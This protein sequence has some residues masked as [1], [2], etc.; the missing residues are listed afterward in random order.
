MAGLTSIFMWVTMP[1][2]M[3]PE[4]LEKVRKEFEDARIAYDNASETLWNSLPYDDQLKVFHAVVK[5]IC[6]AEIEER[7]SYR[8]ALYD[9]FGFEPD[10]YVIG[11][12]CGY[13]DLHNA[14]YDAGVYAKLKKEGKL[15]EDKKDV[16]V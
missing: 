4:Q 5:R 7:G 15:P 2:L 16:G 12:D 6:K 14:L 8:Y 3:D 10:A 1:K 9:V 13:L 11:M